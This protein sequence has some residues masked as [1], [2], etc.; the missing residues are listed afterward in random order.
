M[1]P[2]QVGAHVSHRYKLVEPTRDLELQ[3]IARAHILPLS[4]TD[5]L[6]KSDDSGT[7]RYAVAA[8]MYCALP[9]YG[10]RYGLALA[11]GNFQLLRGRPP[12]PCPLD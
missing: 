12:L 2:R 5:T 4:Y 3:F 1:R 8:V 10:L 6:S 7:L 11:T 9:H